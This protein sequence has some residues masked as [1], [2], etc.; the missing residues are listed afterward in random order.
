M[1]EQHDVVIIG[2]GLAGLAAARDLTASGVDVL[3]LEGSD[4]VGGRVRTDRIDG[5]LLDRGFQLYNPSYAEGA[6][7]LDLDALDLRPFAP[8]VIAATPSGPSRLGDPRRLPAWATSALAGRN[9]S[10]G[11]KLKFARY[12]ATAALTPEDELFDEPDGTAI[13][14]LRRAGIDDRLLETVLRPFLS[15][16][17]L[18]AELTTSRR[19]LD[20]IL[21][22]FV[23]GT[24]SVPAQGMQAIPEQMLDRLPAGTVRLETPASALTATGVRTKSGVVK[25]KATVVAT[26]AMA[27]THLVPGLVVPPGRDATTWYFLA[28]TPGTELTGGDAALIVDGLG[29][30]LNT[31]VL[32]NAA[33][34]YASDGRTLIAASALGL[35]DSAEAV[36]R[37][38]AH[39][40]RLY[41]TDTAG[42]E[43]IATY[44]I[45]YA[46][47]AMLPPLAQ[48]PDVEMSGGIFLAG[49]HR[50]SASIQGAL[51]SGRRAAEAVASH[52]GLRINQ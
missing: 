11:S 1:S 18:E 12:A 30:V 20:L 19:F 16:V 14:A 48:Q 46:L 41:G 27:A 39:L 50:A 47:P 44:A 29:P 13:D 51:L 37:A 40:A 23:R 38:K 7:L 24:P 28:D 32:T 33:P 36:T 25:C 21:R 31:V 8:G 9:G 4:A 45:P 35:Q 34:S 42:W 26:D 2:A 17:F 22:S 3:V 10:L 5:L 6:R 43:H 52:L 15:G 49:D